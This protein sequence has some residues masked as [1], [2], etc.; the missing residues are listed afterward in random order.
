MGVNPQ[1]ETLMADIRQT[2]VV[3]GWTDPR[4]TE[5]GG[6]TSPN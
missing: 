3:E 6:G 1:P 4:E 2:I 5:G